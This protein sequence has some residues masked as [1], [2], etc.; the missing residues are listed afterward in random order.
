M[1][2]VH[3]VNF[4]PNILYV[5]TYVTK[6]GKL[7]KCI[8]YTIPLFRSNWGRPNNIKINVGRFHIDSVATIFLLVTFRKYEDSSDGAGH[9]LQWHGP[10]V[11]EGSLQ[12]QATQLRRLQ[13]EERYASF[14]GV[15]DGRRPFRDKLKLWKLND[16]FFKFGMFFSSTVLMFKLLKET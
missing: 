8:F 2:S 16:N 13:S 12:A 3:E 9:Q 5:S 7:R 1:R 15:A 11:H 4:W 6:Y 10:E 14:W